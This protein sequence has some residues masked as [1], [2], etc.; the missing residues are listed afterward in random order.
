MELLRELGEEHALRLAAEQAAAAA[1]SG[2]EGTPPL[3]YEMHFVRGR[4][5]KS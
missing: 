2:A 4:T 1:A 3:D 5:G